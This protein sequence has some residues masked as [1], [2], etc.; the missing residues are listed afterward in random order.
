MK[1]A[2]YYV[3]DNVSLIL[4]FSLYFISSVILLTIYITLSD[5]KN[6]SLQRIKSDIS[7]FSTY[8]T[9]FFILGVLFIIFIAPFLNIDISKKRIYFGTGPV[10]R[11]LNKNTMF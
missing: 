2:L 5:T 3:Y 7:L 4:S 8:I 11:E 10:K 9:I 6:D 1:K